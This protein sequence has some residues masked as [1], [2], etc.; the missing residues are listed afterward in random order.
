LIL[1][2]LP[3][4]CSGKSAFKGR[5]TFA[6]AEPLGTGLAASHIWIVNAKAVAPL[7]ARLREGCP[8]L[9]ITC[10]R[11]IE[12]GKGVLEAIAASTATVDNRCSPS[13]VA[14]RVP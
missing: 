4:L 12:P 2:I 8:S 6:H 7:L 1:P 3:L 10:T 11:D 14:A 9:M 5:G 13:A